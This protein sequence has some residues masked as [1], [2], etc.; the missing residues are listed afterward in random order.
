MALRTSL[1]SFGIRGHF[2]TPS[3]GPLCDH[4]QITYHGLLGNKLGTTLKCGALEVPFGNHLRTTWC[5]FR[6]TC[7]PLGEDTR[8]SHENLF[9]TDKDHSWTTFEEYYTVCLLVTHFNIASAS[10][11]LCKL[12]LSA[13]VQKDIEQKTK[14]SPFWIRS[15]DSWKEI[16]FNWNWIKLLSACPT[17]K[18]ETRIY[19][20]KLCH[21][22]WC[23]KYHH[24]D[25]VL[26]SILWRRRNRMML[27]TF[28]KG[29]SYF[30]F[31]PRWTETFSL[32]SI[33]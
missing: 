23:S 5:Y 16:W 29:L 20:C 13:W 7:W 19:Q 28:I 30:S 4:L 3:K 11:D 31:I 6:V 24:D 17:L 14:L 18:K 25:C 2:W 32:V 27:W 12:D 26:C 8:G 10:T 9:G 22:T 33:C 15:E 21:S 1:W